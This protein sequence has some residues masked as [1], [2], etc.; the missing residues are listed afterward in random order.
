MGLVPHPSPI[1]TMEEV[2]AN[3]K[4]DDLEVKNE[5]DDTIRD[6]ANLPGDL[7]IQI[8][9]HLYLDDVKRFHKVCKSWDALEDPKE[10]NPLTFPTIP[11]QWLVHKDTYNDTVLKFFHG[12]YDHSY[13]VDI[14]ELLS[15]VLLYSNNGWLLLREGIEII[16]FF[17]PFTNERVD[18]PN[19][20]GWVVW[21]GAIFLSEPTA[22]DCMVFG[23]MSV[24]GKWVRIYTI[25]R[26]EGDWEESVFD[27]DED[28]TPMFQSVCSPVFHNGKLY[29]LGAEGKMGVFDLKGRNWTIH[30]VSGRP[31][32]D[33]T[34]ES[35]L[36][37]CNGQL[38]AVF[39]SFMGQ[40]ICVL[41]LDADKMEWEKVDSLGEFMLLISAPT[42]L[43]VKAVIAGMENKIYFPRFYDHQI[44]FYCLKTCL[45]KTFGSFSKE[46]LFETAEQ[47][48][49]C[50]MQPS[51]ARASTPKHLDWVAYS[52][53]KRTSK[54]RYPFNC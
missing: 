31:H 35:Y 17:N 51:A 54:K 11:S 39:L 22:T 21:K 41:A 36:L 27:F 15:S 13:S 42:S 16:F 34:D 49:C 8:L 3:S 18:L 46:D 29:C 45:Y 43:A 33:Q 2:G 14:P 28:D 50:W 40:E 47:L 24:M 7:L 37:E 23:V 4:K 10:H 32:V 19:K 30:D 38:M 1:C 5:N 9:Q 6:W 48:N 25:S 26:G 12:V 53:S 52:G 20:P 44:V